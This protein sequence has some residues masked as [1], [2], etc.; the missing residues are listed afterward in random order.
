MLRIKGVK[1][2]IKAMVGRDPRVNGTSNPF[3]LMPKSFSVSSIRLG[4]PIPQ[5]EEAG[6]VLLGPGD[7]KG[8]LRKTVE[9]CCRSRQNRPARPSPDGISGPIPERGPPPEEEWSVSDLARLALSKRSKAPVRQ[10][11]PGF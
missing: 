3:R 2:L 9:G 4:S 1:V 5:A 7:G 6:A 10:T 11:E 8:D